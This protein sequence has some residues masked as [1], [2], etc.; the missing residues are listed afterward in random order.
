MTAATLASFRRWR[1]LL[2]GLAA[3][4]HPLR[5]AAIGVD[6]AAVGKLVANRS[7]LRLLSLRL[8]WLSGAFSGER[9]RNGSWPDWTAWEGVD[10]A[11]LLSGA[12]LERCGTRLGASLFR[13]EAAKLV[14]GRDVTAFKADVGADTYFFALRQATL[15]RNI[16]GLSRERVG[17]GGLSDMIRRAAGLGLA[18]WLDFL[19]KDLA[20]R[21]ALKLPPAIDEARHEIDS[22]PENEREDWRTATASVFSL[23]FG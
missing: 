11:A 22:W 6:T 14:L 4:I 7:G 9:G 5:W 15:I 21:V 20:F 16:A 8:D 17:T 13:R 2:D 19:P 12:E 18:A 10:A 3:E 1:P 23:T